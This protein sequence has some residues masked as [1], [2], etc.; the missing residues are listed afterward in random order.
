MSPRQEVVSLV[1]SDA[2]AAVQRPSSASADVGRSEAAALISGAKFF[3][4][5]VWGAHVAS[6][7]AHY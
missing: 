7:V 4:A 2:T 1:A 3:G 6:N 5:K